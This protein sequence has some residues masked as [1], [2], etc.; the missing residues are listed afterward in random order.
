MDSGQFNEAAVSGDEA[1]SVVTP[2]TSRRIPVLKILLAVIAA[3]VLIASVASLVLIQL[4]YPRVQGVIPTDLIK[5]R[6]AHVYTAQLPHPPG[7][8]GLFSFHTDGPEDSHASSLQLFEDGVA[9]GPPHT[10]HASIA[11]SGGA[12]S[13]WKDVL[14][15]SSTRGDDPRTSGREYRIAA[16]YTP[17]PWILPTLITAALLSFVLLVAVTIGRSVVRFGYAAL[18]L[19]GRTA[20]KSGPAVIYAATVAGIVAILV[21]SLAGFRQEQVL[22]PAKMKADK[23]HAYL[24]MIQQVD[25]PIPFLEPLRAGGKSS[26]SPFVRLLE[27]GQEIGLPRSPSAFVQTIGEG[28]FL[29]TNSTI[30]FSTPDNSDPLTNGRTYAV[31]ERLGLSGGF[32]LGVVV[33]VG[34]SLL[35]LARKR[36]KRVLSGLGVVAAAGG[37][38]GVLSYFDIFTYDEYVSPANVSVA[39]ADAYTF[40]VSGTVAP[41]VSLAPVGAPTAVG[42]G[43]QIVTC[44]RE[45][46]V[47]ALQSENGAGACAPRAAG[48]QIDV[49]LPKGAGGM[50]A[51]T[52]YRYPV[53]V[54]WYAVT[55]LFLLSALLFLPLWFRLS[56]QRALFATAAILGGAGAALMG[57]NIAG[58]FLPLRAEMPTEFVLGIRLDGPRMPYEEGVEQLKWRADDSAESY[59]LRVN[60]V[61]S[62]S[63]IHGDASTDLG[64]WRLEIPVWENWSLHTFGAMNP[65]F[66]KYRYWDHKKEFE[67]G[68]G[69]C[70]NMSSIVIGYLAENGVPAR[71]VGLNG[72]VVVTAE[73]RPGVWY[74]LDPDYGV[75]LPNSLEEVQNN[76]AIVEAAYRR[77]VHDERT[78]NMVVDYYATTAD[79]SVDASGREGLYYSWDGSAEV[80]RNREQFMEWLKWIA[81]SLM[82]AAGLAIGVGAF[83]LRRRRRGPSGQAEAPATEPAAAAGPA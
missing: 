12:Y 62:D 46:R 47:A 67:R 68:I 37:I 61:V 20:I 36:G 50:E 58:F 5:A 10:A 81:P 14:Y 51:L 27:N 39:Y 15:F 6:G 53:R 79:N 7:W 74:I 33:L 17:A 34:A 21:V 42:V 65:D 80:Y 38:A 83:L 48:V 41:F 1:A 66:R 72:H 76:P 35:L 63:M 30:L 24:S 75:V 82:L 78:I 56:R 44:E 60:K 70:G 55:G 28:R 77:A 45:V 40:S 16:P 32:I 73:V 18:K 69:L 49:I 29:V 19:L 2:R 3:I 64:R 71:T 4:G 9:I 11:G 52:F 25:S 54:H 59:A 23:G 26:S 43:D 13:H 8:P 57:A 22:S 31:Q